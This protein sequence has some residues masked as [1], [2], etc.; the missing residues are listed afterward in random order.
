VFEIAKYLGR[1]NRGGG[2]VG[3]EL[4]SAKFAFRF[5]IRQRKPLVASG[6][7]LNRQLWGGVIPKWY[8]PLGNYLLGLL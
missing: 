6:L 2:E 7:E 4:F 3:D 8:R 5:L 1:S